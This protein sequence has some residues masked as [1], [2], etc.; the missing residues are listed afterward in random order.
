MAKGI[1]FTILSSLYLGFIAGIFQEGIRYPLARK[2]AI[3]VAAFI[4]LG[5]GLAEAVIIPVMSLFQAGAPLTALPFRWRF[6][7]LLERFLVTIFHGCTTAIIAYAYKRNWG[8][9]ALAALMVG[10]GVID[11]LAAYYQLSGSQFA[12]VSSFFTTA[13]IAAGLF[14]F[15]KKRIALGQRTDSTSSNSEIS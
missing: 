7:S 4:G 2:R 12:L 9:K 11:T 3:R 15:L 5:F 10:H 1:T 13:V 6:L 8:L 14:Y